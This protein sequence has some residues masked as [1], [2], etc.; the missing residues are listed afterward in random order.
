MSL[1]DLRNTALR[2]QGFTGASNDMLLAWAK[3]NGASALELNDALLE[4]LKLNGAT[5]LSLPGAWFQFLTDTGYTGARPNMEYDFW[6]DGGLLL[7]PVFNTS[8][9]N[10]LIPSVG[11]LTTFTRNGS[12][13]TIEDFQPLIKP[14]FADE[15]RFWGVRNVKNIGPNYDVSGWSNPPNGNFTVTQ[16]VAVGE[17]Y[18]RITCTTSDILSV[19]DVVRVISESFSSTRYKIRTSKN[20][21]LRLSDATI[22]SGGSYIIDATPNWQLFGSKGTTLVFSGQMSIT[23]G[24]PMDIGDYIDVME[25]QLERTALNDAPSEYV[26]WGTETVPW[27]GLNVDGVRNYT[28]EN[29]NTVVSNIITPAQGNPIPNNTLKGLLI[30][31]ESTNLADTD[32]SGTQTVTI[33]TT[34]DFTISCRGTETFTITLGTATG[35]ISDSTCSES[36]PAHL[37][38][39]GIGTVLITADVSGT[40]DTDQ[41]GNYI[42]QCENKVYHTS[43]IPSPTTGSVTRLSEIVEYVQPSELKVASLNYTIRG[44]FYLP[45]DG[46]DYNEEHFIGSVGSSTD[47]MIFLIRS[48]GVFRATS[49]NASNPEAKDTA[50][51][52]KGRHKFAI[53]YNATTKI[54]DI[55]LDGGAKIS[56]TANAN[57]Q[58]MSSGINHGIWVGSDKSGVNQSDFPIKLFE[59]FDVIIDDADLVTWT[60]L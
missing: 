9:L 57:T 3:E 60:T 52:L 53:S 14:V 5:S 2:S 59:C 4:V 29:G 21:E 18:T 58:D 32:Q 46:V 20:I 24:V 31:R 43:F 44:E 47:R 13:A 50:A 12:D 41:D 6:A 39:I 7:S 42:I 16:H 34:G 17:P 33:T 28:Y 35:S 8:L 48:D 55:F 45:N 15:A 11:T 30:E 40:L 37:N 56:S 36:S 51:L 54:H 38:L 10:T 49:Y 19:L 23:T 27:H 1:P 22:F 25:A 26:S